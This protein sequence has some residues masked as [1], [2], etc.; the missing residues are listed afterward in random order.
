MLLQAVRI[1][2]FRGFTYVTSPLSL[3]YCLL[4]CSIL[5]NFLIKIY[6]IWFCRFSLAWWA[7]TF[8]MTGAAIATIRYSNQ[9]PNVV[10]KT[11]CVVLALISTFTVTALLVSTMLHAFVF[12]DLFLNDIAIAISDRKRKPHKKWLG[13]RYG[14]QD[15]KEIEN[16]LK[17]VNKDE[18]NL[19][20]SAPQS[21]SGTNNSPNSW[22]YLF[23]SRF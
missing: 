10:T 12:R 5:L 7:Y 6:L 14:S 15:S 11:L 13:F 22:R 3:L 23:L 9:V 19:E 16:Y 1:N 18:I 20:D 21:S 8:P 4:N 17:F 2:F